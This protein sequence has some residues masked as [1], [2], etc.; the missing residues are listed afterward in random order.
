MRSNECDSTSHI[1]NCPVL[2]KKL[3]DKCVGSRIHILMKTDREIVG[4]LLELDDFVSLKEEEL[5]N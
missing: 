1:C 2:Q 3:L 4:T 5:L